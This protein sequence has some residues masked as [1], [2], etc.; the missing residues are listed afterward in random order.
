VQLRALWLAGCGAPERPRGLPRRLGHPDTTVVWSTGCFP[1]EW[2]NGRRAGFRCQCPSG[3]GGSSPPS[4]TPSGSTNCRRKGH[5]LKRGRDLCVCGASQHPTL[6]QGRG[7]TSAARSRFR[8]ARDRLTSETIER[9]G[10]PPDVT[11]ADQDHQDR[12]L[13]MPEQP[14]RR[15]GGKWS[16][17]PLHPEPATHRIAYCDAAHVLI[18]DRPR[19]RSQS[20]VCPES[21]G[22]PALDGMRF[23][24]N[25]RA[26]FLASGAGF[27]AC[28]CRE[29]LHDEVG[30]RT[31]PWNGLAHLG[32][33]RP[34]PCINRQRVR[35]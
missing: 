18:C 6:P 2:R 8:I 7:G 35:G 10:D 28:V 29:G 34:H 12:G 1:G 17:R 21:P 15:V 20:Q 22:R 9:A 13:Y 32:S 30:D 25:G 19:A 31:C 3:R 26:T 24:Y 27:S 23:G 4:P 14:N 16:V 11:D 33:T 5:E